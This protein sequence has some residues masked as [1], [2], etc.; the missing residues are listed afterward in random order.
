LGANLSKIQDYET[1]PTGNPSLVL[2]YNKYGDVGNDWEQDILD[3][4]N[5]IDHPGFVPG[6]TT[7]EILENVS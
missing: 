5:I 1:T 4:N 7:L 6:N 2:A 3:R